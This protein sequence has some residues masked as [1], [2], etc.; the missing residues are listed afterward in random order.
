MFVC[1][2][3]TK[4]EGEMPVQ[5]RFAFR[6][7]RLAPQEVVAPHLKVFADALCLTVP[8]AVSARYST[9]TSNSALSQVAFGFLILVVSGCV[10]GS[11]LSAL[12]LLTSNPF[13]T[14]PAA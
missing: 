11:S 5:F 14:L 2:S 7:G 13:S 1:L 4:P 8:V 6:K 9:S 10:F 3:D 12:S